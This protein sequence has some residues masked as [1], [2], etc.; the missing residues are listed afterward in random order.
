M[1]QATKD[2]FSTGRIF[3]LQFIY[4]QYI[5]EGAPYSINCAKETQGEVYRHLVPP[6]E[7]LFDSSEEYILEVLFSA[8]SHM[9]MHDLAAFDKVRV[10]PLLCGV[11]LCIFLLLSCL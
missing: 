6:Y 8:W 10:F 7:D 2:C 11:S 4:A 3:L 5:I 1:D 9:V